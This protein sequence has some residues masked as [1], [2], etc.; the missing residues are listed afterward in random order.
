MLTKFSATQTVNIAVPEVGISVKHY[1][2][3]PQ[4]LVKALVDPSRTERLSAECFRLKMRP[5]DFMSL[6]LQPTV[7]MRIWA[8]ADGVVR[9]ASVGCEI[10]GVEY[11]NRRFSLD[12]IGKL[13]PEK[14]ENGITYLNGRAE[15]SVCV[16]VPPPLNM[17]PKPMLETT[18][19]GLLKSVLLT[20]K[21][22]L[23]H[24]FVADY[25]QWALQ[26][27]TQRDAEASVFSA[28]E[29]AIQT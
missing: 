9:L 20:M 6:R 19:N 21:Q 4:R 10:R 14:E 2:R 23:T 26:N 16:E 18:G 8:N 29:Q 25:R 5:L 17:T 22:R 15:L 11:I 7:D 27:Q 12:L 24:H 1:L 3:Q 28:N 13:A